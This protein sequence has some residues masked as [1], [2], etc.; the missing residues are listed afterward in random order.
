MAGFFAIF[1]GGVRLIT[2]VIKVGITNRLVDK[3]GLRRSLLITPVILLG[4]C[5]ICLFFAARTSSFK[6]TFYLFG[7]LALATDVLRMAVQSPVL[8]AAM[9]PLPTHQRLRGHTL[10]KGLMDPFAFL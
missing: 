4:I 2:L 8:L 9:Q 3:I 10:L 6:N 1:L 7:V 5:L